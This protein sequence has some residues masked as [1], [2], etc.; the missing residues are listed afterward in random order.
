MKLKNK[1]E[2]LIMLHKKQMYSEEEVLKLLQKARYSN[3]NSL[4]TEDW[5]KRFRKNKIT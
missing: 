2:M 1:Q 5:F 3:F 4:A